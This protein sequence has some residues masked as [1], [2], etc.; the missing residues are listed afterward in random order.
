MS[1]SPTSSVTSPG[2]SVTFK[3]EVTG[4]P[5]PQVTWTIPDRGNFTK[6]NVS[7]GI[8]VSMASVLLHCGETEVSKLTCSI[9]NYIKDI[10]S[11]NCDPLKKIRN[12]KRNIHLH[13]LIADQRGLFDDLLFDWTRFWRGHLHRSECG[14]H[15]NI[16]GN[17]HGQR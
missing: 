16:K 8:N 4:D 9:G 5:T 2:K 15:S 14:C 17:S 13:L 10:Y 7:R 3:C 12:I 1:I 11:D 6:S